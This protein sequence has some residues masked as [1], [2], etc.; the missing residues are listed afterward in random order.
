[1]YTSRLFPNTAN[2]SD[3]CVE[4]RPK[5]PKRSKLPVV[6]QSHGAQGYGAS[7]LDNYAKDNWRTQ[8]VASEY[9]MLSG[10]NGGFNTWGN[11]LSVQRLGGHLSYMQSRPDADP[12]NYALIGGSMGAIVSLNYIA[13]ATVKPKCFVGMIPV[14]N[15]NDFVQNNRG[16]YA[17]FINAAYGGAYNEATMGA[18]KSPH[19][20][21]ASAKLMGIPMLLFYGLSDA[22][23][24]PQYTQEFAAADPTNRTL[25]SY[26]SG[27]DSTTLSSVDNDMMMDFIRTYLG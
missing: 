4:T 16:G 10:D 18:T 9:P 1:M 20:M 27:H 5:Y 7:I 8:M 14:M 25:V 11:D 23:C 12:T 13:Q 19:T 3:M 22:L 21:R 2:G 6:L 26:P 24:M 17:S 15:L